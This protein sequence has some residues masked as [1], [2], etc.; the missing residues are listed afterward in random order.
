MSA[1]ERISSLFRP[2]VY[3][4][5]NP[6]TLA[7]AVLVTS[8]AITL[9]GFWIFDIVGGGGIQPYVGII[10]FL[11][12]PGV[13]VMGLLIMPA[14]AIWRRYSLI[15][16]GEL[17]TIYPQVDFSKPLLAGVGLGR[18]PYVC[19][20]HHLQRRFLSRR[21]IHGFDQILR[22]DL[23]HS[24]AAGIHCVFEFAA[25]ARC[26]RGMPYRARRVVVRSLETFGSSPG[27]CSYF[28]YL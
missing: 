12:L 27:F 14:G 16:S 9:I 4:G 25:P 19:E 24:H 7:G 22:A 28:S 1:S 10:F 15:A 2:A 6:L 5:Q 3:L 26:V 20:R 13:F 18:R 11:L 21:R 23:P 8:S 17:P